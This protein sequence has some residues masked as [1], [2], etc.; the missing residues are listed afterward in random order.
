MGLLVILLIDVIIQT[1]NSI[2]K[3]DDFQMILIFN[4]MISNGYY[5]LKILVR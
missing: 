4:Q 5:P 1:I 2:N 3:H